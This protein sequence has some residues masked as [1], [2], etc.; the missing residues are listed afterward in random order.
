MASAP[1]L[2]L[3]ALINGF[4]ITQAIR[5]AATLR[6]ADH[7]HDGARSV[8][9][10]A[11]LTKSHPD[12]LYRLLRALA[13]V[14][15]FREEQERTFA[16]TPMGDCLRTD[17]ATPLGAWAEVVGSPYFWQAWG[18]LLHS[19]QTGEN[20]FQDLN[21]K[22]VWQFRAE[23]PEH[24]A[25]FDR[26]MTQL[27]RAS[28]EA[29]VRA[30]DF[31]PLRHIVDVG[32]GQGLML[33]EILRAHPHIRGTLLDQRSVI[34]RA[35]AVLAERG[36]IDR[37]DIVSGSFFEALPEGADAY[38]MRAVIHDWSDDQAVAILKVCR[39][40]TQN[41]ARLLLVERLV[42]HLNELPATKF[43][44]LNM[45]V[46]PGG[47]ERTREEF[48]DLLARSGFELTRVFAAGIHNVIEA[49]PH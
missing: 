49:R 8:G 10:L 5:V 30:Y 46:S 7:L 18:H 38:L 26:A 14:D 34:A 29:V 48:S 40:A 1:S 37:C 31:S 47:R 6:V 42:G 17:S 41:G 22:N 35:R 20:A 23:H 9:E 28:A 19:V 11:A 32:G 15:V 25:T 16:L 39:R 45:L 44:D 21:G 24:G 3:L 2:D 13:A 36:V 33:A 12:S 27:S 4:Q 43:S